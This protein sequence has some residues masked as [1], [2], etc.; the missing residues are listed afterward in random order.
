MLD[1]TQYFEAEANGCID[2][3][4]KILECFN[5]IA[6]YEK[7]LI[8][9]GNPLLG[10]YLAWHIYWLGT[11]LFV[12][13]KQRGLNVREYYKSIQKKVIQEEWLSLEKS[14]IKQE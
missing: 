12:W 9:A 8:Q 3:D 13:E 11:A 7:Q 14:T 1:M 5:N 10:H 6:Q 2:A 4:K